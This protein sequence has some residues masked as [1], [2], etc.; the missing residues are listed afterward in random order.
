MGSPASPKAISGFE[1][2]AGLY[3]YK[4]AQFLIASDAVYNNRIL[5]HEVGHYLH[6]ELNPELQQEIEEALSKNK[7]TRRF[8]WGVEWRE[9]IAEYA[10]IVYTVNRGSV[11]NLREEIHFG[12]G[13][14]PLV[15]SLAC[16]RADQMYALQQSRL[17]PEMARMD[18]STAIDFMQRKLPLTLNRQ[19]ASPFK[20]RMNAF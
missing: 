19:K 15:Q 16:Q 18:L 5:S 17:L 6:G 10:S 12:T 2:P 4:K 11:F 14:L 13:A 8:W 1:M 3:S 20:A 9:V 7:P